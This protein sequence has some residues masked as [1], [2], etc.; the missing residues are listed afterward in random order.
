M[1]LNT[2]HYS[3]NVY[4]VA[5]KRALPTPEPLGGAISTTDLHHANS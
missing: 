2:G 1:L 5:V 4:V 3:C